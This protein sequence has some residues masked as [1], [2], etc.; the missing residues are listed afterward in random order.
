MSD[1]SITA[2]TYAAKYSA[3]SASESKPRSTLRSRLATCR[4][5]SALLA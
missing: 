3:S 2:L 4:V 5:A 1:V